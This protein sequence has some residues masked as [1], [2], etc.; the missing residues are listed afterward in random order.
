M[1][2]EKYIVTFVDYWRRSSGSTQN[3]FDD[4]NRI[5]KEV[6]EEAQREEEYF[7]EDRYL[8]QREIVPYRVEEEILVRRESESGATY[9]MDEH[10]GGLNPSLRR[11]KVIIFGDTET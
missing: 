3:F 11:R 2:Q 4:S 8:D 5:I 1:N 10:N 9:N 6:E 7:P